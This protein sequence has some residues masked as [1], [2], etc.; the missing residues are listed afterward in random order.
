MYRFFGLRV[1]K[2]WAVALCFV[3]HIVI[4]FY[5]EAAYLSIELTQ[6]AKDIFSLGIVLYWLPLQFGLSKDMF[7]NRG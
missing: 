2:F 5:S 6:N 3:G 4:Q 1:K 7:S